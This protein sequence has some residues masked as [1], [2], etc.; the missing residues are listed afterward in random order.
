MAGPDALRRALCGA[1]GVLLGLLPL[2]RC[3][4]GACLSCGGCA[5]A[6]AVA[7]L[8]GLGSWMRRRRTV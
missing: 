5:A 2:A 4:G 1:A 3:P 7:G 6:A 8:A